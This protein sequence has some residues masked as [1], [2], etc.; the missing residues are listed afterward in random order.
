MTRFW[1]GN[2]SLHGC[3][4]PLAHEIE[5]CNNI[6]IWIWY[7]EGS[8]SKPAG[9]NERKGARKKF[10]TA[11]ARSPNFGLRACTKFKHSTF[12]CLFWENVSVRKKYCFLA[13]LRLKGLK[14]FA[15][16][17]HSFTRLAAVRWKDS[18]SGG[19]KSWI[20]LNS[21]NDFLV[22]FAQCGDIVVQVQVQVHFLH[23]IY[24]KRKVQLQHMITR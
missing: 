15:F 7:A 16:S 4:L 23:T 5:P 6:I 18:M 8:E 1:K 20:V 13:K 22:T 2:C 3:A 19:Q 24:I 21:H 17:N 12:L 11:I 10:G 14:K 9:K